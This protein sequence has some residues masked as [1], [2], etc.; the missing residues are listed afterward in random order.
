MLTVSKH[1]L[2]GPWVNKKF[3]MEAITITKKKEFYTCL[4]IYN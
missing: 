1:K 2:L 4:K 3:P